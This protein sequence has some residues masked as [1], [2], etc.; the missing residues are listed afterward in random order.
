MT[1]SVI[2]PAYQ[3]AAYLERFSL[4]SLA[5]Q[6]WAAWEAIIIDDGSTDST[7]AVAQ[8]W[9]AQ[10]PRYR[11]LKLEANQGLAAALNAGLKASSGEI[12]AFLEQDDIWLPDKL[13]RQLAALENKQI[14]TCNFFYFDP[15]TMTITGSGGGNFSTLC[16]RR[17]ILGKIFPLA[18]DRRF[19]G[20]EDGLVA[21]RLALLEAEGM[22]KQ[23]AVAHLDNGLVAVSRHPD[24]LSGHGRSRAYAERYQAARQFFSH[25]DSPS[26]KRLK[27]R[28]IGGQYLNLFFSCL[29]ARL[30]KIGRRL[31]FTLGPARRLRQLQVRPD[32]LAA[33]S[34]LERFSLK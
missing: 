8:Q 26:L 16:V 2:I 25:C 17:E 3:G 29:P 1:V 4:P 18:E 12:I 33:R 10:D 5:A 31:V 30:Q 32:Y 15:R 11:Y 20:I 13:S 23:T 7:A 22:L 28:W 14:A 19:L 21:G 9:C 24:S 6:D 34:Y 27:R